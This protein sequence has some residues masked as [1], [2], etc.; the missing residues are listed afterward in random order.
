MIFPAHHTGLASEDLLNLPAWRQFE[1]VLIDFKNISDQNQVVPVLAYIP[2]VT[3]VYSEYTTLD[4]GGNWLAMRDKGIATSG[5]DEKAVQ[6]LTE[7][8]GIEMISFLPAFKDAARQ[9][10]LVYYRFDDH[11]NSEGSEIAARVTAD[12]LRAHIDGAVSS[13]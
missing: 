2:F 8:V 6:A 10:K 7:R 5:N 1:Q 4:S 13:K 3:E 11:W 12:A 9:G